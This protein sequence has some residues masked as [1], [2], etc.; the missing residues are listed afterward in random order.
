MKTTPEIAKLAHEL[1]LDDLGA[2]ETYLV[3]ALLLRD[4]GYDS[5]AD[6]F[7]HESQHERLHATMQIE[8]LTYLEV[9]IDLSLRPA[10]PPTPTKPRDCF[11]HSLEMEVRVA[12][13]LRD[14]C[15]L[16]EGH[17]EGT[18][19]LAEKLLV[20]TE[21]DHILWLRQQLGQI[22]RIGEGNYLGQMIRGQ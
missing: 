4:W 19:A 11:E 9:P 12:A 5:L 3:Y 17:D 1:M 18:R 7:D 16:C 22:E 14:L 10:S 6:H 2:S 13:K 20:E 15:A 21:M 8:R